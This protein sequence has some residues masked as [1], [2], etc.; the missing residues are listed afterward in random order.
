MK[1]VSAVVLIFLLYFVC[2]NP[3]VAT[4]V[5]AQTETHEEAPRIMR[6]EYRFRIE[7]Q[8]QRITER[9]YRTEEE[10]F[11]VMEKGKNYTFPTPK[12]APKPLKYSF[13]MYYNGYA[14]TM[15]MVNGVGSS[16]VVYMEESGNIYH[17]SDCLYYMEIS[18]G[19]Y[20]RPKWLTDVV[21]DKLRCEFC[22][23]DD[24]YYKYKYA[25][26]YSELSGL[27]AKEGNAQ[28]YVLIN[29]IVLSFSIA[30][31]I[32]LI[33]YI[34]KYREIKSKYNLLDAIFKM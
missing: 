25:V 14:E 29:I 28:K 1:K 2:V 20:S 5:V 6:T 21:S 24:I 18:N 26:Q 32:G 13:E 31:L 15:N 33:I 11:Q 8:V 17:M 34:K 10:L 12:K 23:T 19:D 9:K 30:L 3:L 4:E 16:P 22:I 27:R 7:D